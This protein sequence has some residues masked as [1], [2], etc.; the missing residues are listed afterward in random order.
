MSLDR[1]DLPWFEP[2]IE[3]ADR[4]V[5]PDF[6][7]AQFFYTAETARRLVASLDHFSKPCCLCTPRL[8]W[9]WHERGRTVR[10]LDY[11]VRFSSLPGFRRFDLLRPEPLDEDFD[12]IVVDPVYYPAATLAR[13]VRA[14]VRPTS[15]TALYISFPVQRESEL[16]SAFGGFGLRALRTRLAWC[17]L[18]AEHRTKFRL[19]G[20]TP[21]PRGSRRRSKPAAQREVSL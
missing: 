19:Y 1:L 21:L 8:A 10:L 11:D 3:H 5:T 9:E 6:A 7:L 18:K 14:L 20:R 17:N 16:L 13:A 15:T 4:F 2:S 12:V